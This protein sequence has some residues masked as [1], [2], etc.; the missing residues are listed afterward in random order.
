[1][2][3]QV[4][5]ERYGDVVRQVAELLDEINER[6]EPLD[7][8]AVASSLVAGVDRSV[9]P[10]NGY[11]RTHGTSVYAEITLYPTDVVAHSTV[12]QGDVQREYPKVVPRTA[13][14]EKYA[15]YTLAIDIDDA[16]GRL[17]GG[18]R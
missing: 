14:V 6:D 9:E 7:T 18:D 2:L 5:R 15:I 1:M 12:A 11:T 3:E 16:L 10:E 13:N 8:V 4:D 17:A